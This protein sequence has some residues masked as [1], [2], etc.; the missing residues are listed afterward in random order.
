M[1]AATPG[2]LARE[3]R[4]THLLK[5]RPL[6]WPAT[7]VL[8]QRGRRV[9]ASGVWGKAAPRAGVRRASGKHK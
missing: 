9:A 6:G 1:A 3:P 8:H 5:G 7:T 4:P 2:A